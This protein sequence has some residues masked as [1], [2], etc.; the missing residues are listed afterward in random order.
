[1]ATEFE[2]T[3]SYERTLTFKVKAET[4][5]DAF[6]H[7]ASAFMYDDLQPD[8]EG[9][10]ELELQTVQIGEREIR[11]NQWFDFNAPKVNG[12]SPRKYVA[13]DGTMRLGESFDLEQLLAMHA[14]V[15]EPGG[16]S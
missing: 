13:Y 9:V 16:K 1:M 15:E 2:I 4:A 5:F 14:V 7:A 6:S 11:V 12:L 3:L 10:S 8:D